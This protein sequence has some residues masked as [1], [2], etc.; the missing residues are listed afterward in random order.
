MKLPLPGPAFD[1]KVRIFASLQQLGIAC[2]KAG[3]VWIRHHGTCLFLL[4]LRR[5]IG[6][7]L[8]G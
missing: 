4:F 3:V 6:G 2:H 1:F 7:S 8:M 5:K